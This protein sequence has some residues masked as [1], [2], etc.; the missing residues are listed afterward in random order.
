MFYYA[1]KIRIVEVENDDERRLT[2]MVW[3]RMPFQS[4]MQLRCQCR[5]DSFLERL[6]IGALTK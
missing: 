4:H 6:G 5:L 2:V 3:L 1:R